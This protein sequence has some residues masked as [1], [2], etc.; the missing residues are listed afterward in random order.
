MSRNKKRLPAPPLPKITYE[1]E[2]LTPVELLSH[3]SYK[4]LVIDNPPAAI[5][6]LETIGYY[7]L[8]IYCRSRQ[9]GNKMFIPWVT[10]SD[11]LNLYHFDKKLR[12]LCLDAIERIE[13][14]LRA[15]IN[16]RAAASLGS[17]FYMNPENFERFSG[18]NNFCRYAMEDDHPIV[19]HY[20]NR[21]HTPELPPIW[22]LTEILSIGK[23]S[24]LYADLKISV[25]KSIAKDDFGY[26]EGSLTSWFRCIADF[27]NKCAHHERIWNAKM[28]SNM[29]S[30]SRDL[31]E[32]NCQDR[33]YSRAV[34]IVALLRRIEPG[35]IWRDQL[36]ELIKSSNFI[37]PQEMGFPNDWMSLPFWN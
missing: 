29:P 27:R 25:R 1:K 21:Y 33:F 3:L 17:H 15:S 23:L 12:I 4:G 18:F 11:I 10:F 36:K 28:L 8:N 35:D 37:T 24:F 5:R 14:A 26:S 32:L 34:L 2:A 20:F 16:N 30:Y 6:A 31:R 19:K 9:Y 22:A 7:R 13:V